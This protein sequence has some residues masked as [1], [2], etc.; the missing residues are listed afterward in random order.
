MTAPAAAAGPDGKPS[1]EAFV[2]A[3]EAVDAIAQLDPCDTAELGITSYKHLLTDYGLE[4]M[5]A[6]RDLAASLL[7]RAATVRATAQDPQDLQALDVMVERLRLR[8]EGSDAGDDYRRMDV[9]TAPPFAFR[10]A[11]ELMSPQ[12]ANIEA[13][14]AAV[15]DALA[16]WRAGL[17]HGSALGHVA[18]RRQVLAVARQTA[19]IGAGW[20]AGFVREQAGGD[21]LLEGL[22][23]EAD[24][25]YQETARWLEQD[26]APLGAEQDGVGAQA[27]GRSVRYWLGEEIDL[28]ETSAWG[29]AELRRIHA[30]ARAEAAALVP[31]GTLLDA[32]RFLDASPDHTVDGGEALLAYLQGVTQEGF[33]AADRWFDIAPAIRRCDVRLAGPGSAAAPYYTA[34]SEDLAR[35]GTTWYPTMGKDRFETWH[36]RSTWFHEAVPGHHLQLATVMVEREHLSRFQ[37][38]LGWTSGYGEGW[39]LYA[40]HL[41]DELG[42]F[43]DPGDRL[44]YLSAQA[45]RAARVVI[46][47]GLHCGLPVPADNGL[48]LPAGPWTPD[49]AERVLREFALLDEGFAA[50]EVNRYLGLPGQAIS[51]KVGERVWL[52]LRQEAKDRLGPAFDLR[53]W[54]MAALR[55]GH[56][57]LAPFRT[58]MASYGAPT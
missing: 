57:G 13:R 21:A 46:D 3:D 36:L 50:S 20:Y 18:A 42:G 5:Q 30:E 52:D 23:A 47:I 32:A 44:G 53:D 8:V 49:L 58:L 1:S 17:L 27:Y 35:P 28:H 22:A 34:P 40:E 54:H 2:L 37:R 45:M 6:R 39:A 15:P 55:A 24:A 33:D 9:L 51:Y 43:P 10:M 16:S 41:M 56:M 4:G 14:L 12:R 29:W 25:A 26:F 11:F 7:A 31:G 48:G 38:V 19:A